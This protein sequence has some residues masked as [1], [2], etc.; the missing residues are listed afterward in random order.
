VAWRLSRNMSDPRATP[1]LLVA[2]IAA[3]QHGVVSIAQIQAAGLDKH[4]V[5]HRVRTARL[6]RIH[7]GVFAVGH[8][9]LPKEGRWM[10]ATLAGGDAAVLSH[11]SAASLWA[12]LPNHETS[13]TEI[14]VPG[15]GGRKRRAGIRLHRCPSLLPEQVTRHLGIPVT[16]PS[17]TIADLRGAVSP[18]ELRRARRQAEVLGLPLGS[19]AGPDGTRSELEFLFLDLCRK[20]RLPTPEVNIRISSLLVDFA[21]RDRQLIVETDGYKYH[22]GRIA[23]E[24]DRARDLKLRALGYDVIRLTYR[25]VMDR[26]E[27]VVAALRMGLQN[28]ANTKAGRAP[29]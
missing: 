21:W 12:L 9:H 15:D 24:G 2:R 6:H 16:T 19:S 7:R 8:S 11:R 5:L 18:Q 26:P 4:Q 28:R 29:R 22:R 17:R 25:Q 10:A 1:D 13:D 20:H 27:E 3:R 14:S 23:F